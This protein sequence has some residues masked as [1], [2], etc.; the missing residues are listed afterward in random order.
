MLGL[1]SRPNHKVFL[2]ILS[3]GY[4]AALNALHSCRFFSSRPLAILNFTL[5]LLFC[6]STLLLAQTTKGPD[7]SP[8]KSQNPELHTLQV[9]GA[10]VQALA[11]STSS[12][13]V[14]ASGAFGTT[15]YLWDLWDLF[16]GDDQV[17]TLDMKNE[18]VR[19]IAFSPAEQL[20]AIGLGRYPSKGFVRL[21]DDSSWKV[22]RTLEGHSGSLISNLAFSPDG[23]KLASG[24]TD[25][26]VWD[27]ATGRILHSFKGGTTVIVPVDI[28]PTAQVLAHGSQDPGNPEPTVVTVRDLQS[29]RIIWTLKGHTGTIKSIRFSPDGRLLA[30]GG[31]DQKIRVWDVMTGRQIFSVEGQSYNAQPIAFTPDGAMLVSIQD[32]SKVK[33]WDVKTGRDLITF[34]AH[35][36]HSISSIAISSS[37][38]TLC[39]GST[40]HTVKVWGLTDL[41][42][43]AGKGLQSPL[44]AKLQV[45]AS[46]KT[47]PQVR[48]DEVFLAASEKP[49]I[50]LNNPRRGQQVKL[51]MRYTVSSISDGSQV[52]AV[53]YRRI[54]YGGE[55]VI[56]RKDQRQLESGTYETFQPL[57]LPKQTPSGDYML[58]GIVR[59][60]GKEVSKQFNFKLE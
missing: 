49:G 23:K 42:A 56:E 21:V 19:A 37:G 14:A 47:E 10:W 26:K 35:R 24:S 28:S 54:S 7:K 32:G 17:D 11:I 60:G 18:Q 48:I 3:A 40:D 43:L 15:V 50:P 34:I 59:I 44:D 51:V 16:W 45:E 33:F 9:P 29:G 46:I 38:D 4:F 1:S 6:T 55:Q 2:S 36:G 39:T 30:S 5:V 22:V 57:T 31:S 58:H 20:V 13:K 27:V 53:E 41:M 52:D 12:D 25:V 8:T